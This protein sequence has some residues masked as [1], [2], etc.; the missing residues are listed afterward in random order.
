M[1]LHKSCSQWITAAAM[2]LSPLTFVALICISYW[3]DL[4][5]KSFRHF[6][7][8][9]ANSWNTFSVSRVVTNYLEQWRQIYSDAYLNMRKRAGRRIFLSLVWIHYLNLNQINTFW[10]RAFSG[11][12]Y[13]S[14]VYISHA[15]I[16]ILHLCI[17]DI[18]YYLSTCT[19][20]LKT[21][22]SVTFFAL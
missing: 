5:P 10:M 12:K 18:R 6:D 22:S 9:G 14:N 13:E 19:K 7:E 20:S 8:P 15:Q 16:K 1:D 2:S 4:D 3:R 21:N 11:F 17:E